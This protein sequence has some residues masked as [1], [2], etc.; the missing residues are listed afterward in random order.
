MNDSN[1]SLEQLHAS[2][3]DRILKD[4]WWGDTTLTDPA[5]RTAFNAVP[6][7]RFTPDTWYEWIDGAW[8]TRRRA[9]DPDVWAT[10]VYAVD[11]PLITQVDPDTGAPTCSLS[12]PMLVA[13][14]LGA[15]D[16]KPGMR[17]F[18]SGTGT[19]WTAALMSMM[20]DRGVGSGVDSVEYDPRLAIQASI[21]VERVLREAPWRGRAVSI[22]PGDGEAGGGWRGPYDVTTATHAV[23]RI[24]PAWIAQTRPGGLVCAPLSVS[25][26]GLDL[27]VKLIVDRAGGASGKVLFPLAFMRSRTALK[28]AAAA[29]VDDEDRTGTTSL[30]LPAILAAKQAW[31]LQL[32]VP[33]ITITGPAEEDG[34]ECVWLSLADGSWAVGYTPV[35]EPWESAIVEQHGP[36]DVWAAAESAWAFWN[37]AGRRPLDEYGLSVAPDGVHKLWMGKPGNV[38]SVL[39]QE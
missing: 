13:A 20:T 21:N 27:Y 11:K 2:L 25:A 6:R 9:D 24:P 8:A 10:A 26:D 5:W 37:A 32:G 18:E 23:R 38:V 33:G 31:V 34:D 3:P 39:P 14:M 29:W 30:D 28:Q 7:H 22:S 12:A 17:V 4:P 1:L 36:T 35:G 16:L 19:G 15:L